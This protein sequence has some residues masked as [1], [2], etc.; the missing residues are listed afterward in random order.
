[1][2]PVKIKIT[3]F[4]EFLKNNKLGKNTVNDFIAS[5][6]APSSTTDTDYK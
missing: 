1:M 2:E 3:D 4:L 6:S 5:D